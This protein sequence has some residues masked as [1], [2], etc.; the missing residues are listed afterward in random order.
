MS[1]RPPTRYLIAPD[2]F[3]GTLSAEEAAAAMARGVRRNDPN[4]VVIEFPFADGGEGTV[5]AVVAA[6]GTEH[7]DCVTGPL[8]DPVTA[9]WAE[10]ENAAVI[11]MA[12][13]SGLRYV[14]PTPDTALRADT[15]GVGQLIVR[16]L[17]AGA[18]EIVIGVGG[19]ATTDGGF[20]ALRALGCRFL[21]E[22]NQEI[23]RAEE[24]V[25]V[26]TLD[27]TGLDPRVRDVSIEIC[28]D[29]LSPLI[30][31]DGAAEVFGPQK[32]A[33]RK[34]IDGLE[35][36]LEALGK[37]YQQHSADPFMAQGGAAGGLAAG[38]M[39][40]LAG[41]VRGGVE[42][43]AEL[44][45]LDDRISDADIVLVGE[46]SLDDQSRFGK[47]PVGIARRA[48]DRGVPAIAIV[49]TT[50]LDRN[51]LAADG[52]IDIVSAVEVATTVDDALARPAHHVEA[53][54]IA[55]LQHHA[56]ERLIRTPRTVA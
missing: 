6:G 18:Q 52:I 4:A 1:D 39:A 27:T 30:G 26:A 31:V 35:R 5:R 25:N 19:S 8:G 42:V 14:T 12:E 51:A 24:L 47:T 22:S 44:L 15:T 17:D 16:A 34:A 37:V 41:R 29:V 54:T 33:D 9:T 20:G 43:L 53:A 23:R 49:G 21:D 55:A 10:F 50:P 13:A 28:A 46:G 40:I 2:K 38:A 3:K 32:G 45:H 36:R 48:R 7:R 11:E 56:G